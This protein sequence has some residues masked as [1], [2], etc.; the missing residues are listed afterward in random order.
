MTDVSRDARQL[1]ARLDADAQTL[2]ALLQDAQRMVQKT[3][4]EIGSLGTAVRGTA[5][6]ARAA[7]EVTRRTL[8]K[9][10]ATLGAVD[11]TL[12]GSEPL[13]HQLINTLQ[14]LAAA[15]RSVRTL[16]DYLDR[17]PEALLTGKGNPGGK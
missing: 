13:G 10:Q 8:E 15:A 7:L 1:L 2:N 6:E 5:D 12:G 14:D 16:A 9:A 3:E 4:G 11:G 17:H